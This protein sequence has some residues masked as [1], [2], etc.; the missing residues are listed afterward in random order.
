MSLITK[1]GGNLSVLICSD[2]NFIFN[3]MSFS[4]WYSIRR[5]LPDAEIAVTISRNFSNVQL[6][7]WAYRSGVKFFLHKNV[8]KENLLYL[9]KIYGVYV[10]LKEKLINPPFLV[11]DADMMSV[12]NLSEHSLK[13]LNKSEFATNRNGTIWY[14]ADNYL[15]KIAGSINKMSSINH[16]D[17]KH[18]DLFSLKEVFG[19]PHII[20][21]LGNEAYESDLG[22]F[23]HYKDRCGNFFRKEFEKG[24]VHPPFR[25]QSA[26]RT[27]NMTLAET[28]IFNLW[29]QMWTT[30]EVLSK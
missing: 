7:N 17:L 15:E 28:K 1:S 26:L 3:W 9:N 16:V 5:N 2:Y 20:E 23:A 27:N 11:V 24:F 10:A 21:D 8:G 29:L 18:L 25:D 22:T 30:F 6:Y 19:E 14:F 4:A 13:I 12:K